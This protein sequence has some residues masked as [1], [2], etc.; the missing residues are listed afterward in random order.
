M[1]KNRNSP[2]NSSFK[3]KFN[4]KLRKLIVI[5]VLLIAGTSVV[6]FRYYSRPGIVVCNANIIN[7]T[8]PFINSPPTKESIRTINKIQKLENFSK[9][10]NCLY[11]LVNHYINVSDA[12]NSRLYYDKLEA[13]YNPLI[14]YS[15]LFGKETKNPK[16]LEPIVKFLEK[17]TKLSDD[18][19]MGSQQ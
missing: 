18:N 12:E 2:K 14:G 5:T 15:E 4:S 11:I 8:A 3:L 9:D 17:Q 6:A 1:N 16:T 7:Q 19:I 13:V 10:V